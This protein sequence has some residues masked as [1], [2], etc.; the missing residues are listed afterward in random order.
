MAFHDGLA[1][2]PKNDDEFW[3]IIEETLERIS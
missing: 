3:G 1:G 2:N